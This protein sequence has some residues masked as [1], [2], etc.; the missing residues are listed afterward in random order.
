MFTFVKGNQYTM[1]KSTLL[2][3]A[4]LITAL[5]PAAQAEIRVGLTSSHH[6]WPNTY[7]DRDIY[8]SGID[9]DN[10]VYSRHHHRSRHS[11]RRVY[12]SD[13]NYYTNGTPGYVRYSRQLDNR[14]IYFNLFGN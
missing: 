7:S 12:D 9:V 6:F 11:Y 8:Y 1:K 5:A 3:I 13:Y 2:G 14:G 10:H 4:I